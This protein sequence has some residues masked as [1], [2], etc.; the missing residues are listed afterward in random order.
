MEAATVPASPSDRARARLVR[1][2]ETGLNEPVMV[3]DTEPCPLNFAPDELWTLHATLLDRI[4]AESQD[5]DDSNPPP[6]TIYRIFE[7][8]ETDDHVFTGHERGQIEAVVEDALE[9]E[10]VPERDR[11]AMER[12]LGRLTVRS[13]S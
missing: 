3:T 2:L 1:L 13:V 12:I 8:L 6:V 5:P 7:K 9:R 10:D 4:E 11:R